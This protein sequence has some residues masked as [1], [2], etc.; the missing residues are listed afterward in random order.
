MIQQA[1][2]LLGGAE[3][4]EPQQDVLQFGKGTYGVHQ[5]CRQLGH[6]PVEFLDEPHESGVDIPELC[7]RRVSS[8][9][10]EAHHAIEVKVRPA[11][12][13]QRGGGQ[14]MCLVLWAASRA[15]RA[16]VTAASVE[17]RSS[18]MACLEF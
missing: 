7:L 5:R 17:S 13:G 8:V 18:N 9:I 11:S 14:R 2:G 10:S 3:A 16:T 6:S 4:V 12:A 1:G 15:A